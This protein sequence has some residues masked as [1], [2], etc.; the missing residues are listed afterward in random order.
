MMSAD[1]IRDKISKYLTRQDGCTELLATSQEEVRGAAGNADMLSGAVRFFGHILHD[2]DWLNA[3]AGANDGAGFTLSDQDLKYIIGKKEKDRDAYVKSFITAV[4]NDYVGELVDARKAPQKKLLEQR[5]EALITRLSARYNKYSFEFQLSASS[6]KILEAE[7]SKAQ[8]D[9]AHK[10]ELEAINLDHQAVVKSQEEAYE[11]REKEYQDALQASEKRAEES[12]VQSDLD[13][14]EELGKTERVYQVTLER[15]EGERQALVAEKDGLVADHAEFLRS[16]Q[17]DYERKLQSQSEGLAAEKDEALSGLEASKDGEAQARIGELEAEYDGL[18]QAQ[19]Q[20]HSAEVARLKRSVTK[21][22]RDGHG[23]IKSA[24]LSSEYHVRLYDSALDVL[25]DGVSNDYLGW[26]RQLKSLFDK[27]VGSMSY[28]LPKL[29][30]DRANQASLDLLEGINSLVGQLGLQDFERLEDLD[31]LQ[32]VNWEALDISTDLVTGREEQE[33]DLLGNLLINVLKIDIDTV[34][35]YMKHKDTKDF[36]GV[37]AKLR[38]LSLNLSKKAL[39]EAKELSDKRLLLNALVKD[40]LEVDSSFANLYESITEESF[41]EDQ[42]DG[43]I[44][45][46]LENLDLA[47]AEHRSALE[48]YFG[49]PYD[50]EIKRLILEQ[51]TG[52]QTQAQESDRGYYK[53]D[54]YRILNCYRTFDQD[55]QAYVAYQGEVDYF[56]E[57]QNKQRLL[58]RLSSPL[59]DFYHTRF[60]Y[61]R[62]EQYMASIEDMPFTDKKILAD[63][64]QEFIYAFKHSVSE[65]YAEDRPV[66][67]TGGERLDVFAKAIQRVF[68]ANKGEDKVN[69]IKDIMLEY[70]D[71][72]GKANHPDHKPALD[73]RTSNAVQMLL[74]LERLSDLINSDIKRYAEILPSELERQ[75]M[76]VDGLGDVSSDGS[77]SRESGSDGSSSESLGEEEFKL[78]CLLDQKTELDSL[79]VTKSTIASLRERRQT[80]QTSE[81]VTEGYQSYCDQYFANQEE[82]T[83]FVTQLQDRSQAVAGAAAE[84]QAGAARGRSVSVVTSGLGH[85]V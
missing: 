1:I 20:Q 83:D 53:V 25:D 52:F 80:I 35:S 18:S 50:K 12:K 85:R 49:S 77:G 44:K 72:L 36:V 42:S 67:L 66:E 60:D 84:D 43:A 16:L 78:K 17:E 33:T 61:F 41:V 22:Q 13:H 45:Y 7:E 24:D 58:E 4:T 3:I 51:K 8:S 68:R 48:V 54:G 63:M 40:P 30:G 32:S 38:G 47:S 21:A 11:G 10:K 55:R 79:V 9:L 26:K 76:I 56:V 82:G 75:Q 14:T 2:D 57:L 29:G 65:R 23:A 62:V 5:M 81:S 6:E 34:D 73:E 70:K 69:A 39:T 27:T 15:V 31:G 64:L 71:S 59:E 19:T 74:S 28:T 37:M 46:L